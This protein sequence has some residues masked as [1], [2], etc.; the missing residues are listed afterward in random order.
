MKITYKPVLGCK[1]ITYF[2]KGFKAQISVTEVQQ[3]YNK[4]KILNN[5]LQS[6]IISVQETQLIL[7]EHFPL[8]GRENVAIKRNFSLCLQDFDEN[9]FSSL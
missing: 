1:N 2:I 4:E 8:A 7:K 9:I 6:G 5:S 3:S